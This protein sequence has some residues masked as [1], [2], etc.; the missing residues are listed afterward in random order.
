MRAPQLFNEHPGTLVVGATLALRDVPV[1]SLSPWAH[2]LVLHPTC[3][4][5]V[6]PPGQRRSTAR[7]LGGARTPGGGRGGTRGGET[8][9][10]APV[11]CGETEAFEAAGGY[12]ADA[13][14]LPRM[15][16]PLSASDGAGAGDAGGVAQPRRQQ[17]PEA[18]SQAVAWEQHEQQPSQQLSQPLQ[19]SAAALRSPL[20][21]L[22]D[23]PSP[24][25]RRARAEGAAEGA[26]QVAKAARRGGGGTPHGDRS[27]PGAA[28]HRESIDLS[29]P[30]RPPHQ[31]HQPHQPPRPQQQQSHWPPPQHQPQQQRVAPRGAPPLA[32][33]ARAAAP[34]P[35]DAAPL[36]QRLAS[37]VDLDEEAELRRIEAG[38]ASPPAQR[39]AQ[40][41]PARPPPAQPP[42]TPPPAQPPAQ[43]HPPAQPLAVADAP[44]HGQQP[45]RLFDHKHDA[46]TPDLPFHIAAARREYEELKAVLKARAKL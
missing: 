42:P 28:A 4:L 38:E 40:P 18:Q 7:T 34:P 1:L 46:T 3:V 22:A 23:A 29:S 44:P 11:Q 36:Y 17:Q 21:Q 12:Q 9:R 31:P 10:G 45:S 20:A 27:S 15:M 24:Q 25:R 16:S 13:A 33:L 26:A 5:H 37:D 43:P 6:V 8:A 2:H 35:H 30:Q 14:S 32:P 39:P 19:P 41:P